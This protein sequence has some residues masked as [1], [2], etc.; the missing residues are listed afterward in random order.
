[1]MCAAAHACQSSW[2]S[3]LVS[4]VSRT[5]QVEIRA[6]RNILGPFFL[7]MDII[8]KSSENRRMCRLGI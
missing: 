8:S 3:G 7:A 2:L 5:D 6:D 1:M 4:Q